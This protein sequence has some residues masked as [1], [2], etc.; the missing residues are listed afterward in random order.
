MELAALAQPFELP[1]ELW[2]MVAVSLWCRKFT[3]YP[4]PTIYRALVSV[5]KAMA[6]PTAKT[7]LS[8]VTTIAGLMRVTL[9]NGDLHNEHGPS[10]VNRDGTMEWYSDGLRHRVDGPAVIHSCGSQHWY[11]YGR[12]SK[13]ICPNGHILQ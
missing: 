10:V 13:V 6:I 5:S 3:E 7:K 4:D 1:V 11:A 9:P 12:A 8:R 2:H